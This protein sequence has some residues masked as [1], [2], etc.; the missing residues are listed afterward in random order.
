MLTH[1]FVVPYCK[2]VAFPPTDDLTSMG[3]DYNIRFDNI[4]EGG[5]KLYTCGCVTRSGQKSES[6]HDYNGHMVQA[7]NHSELYQHGVENELTLQ[8]KN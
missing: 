1:I 3:I 6:K 5:L 7:V 4:T 8:S 2:N